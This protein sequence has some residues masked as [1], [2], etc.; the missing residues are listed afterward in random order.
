MGKLIPIVGILVIIGG[1]VYLA[2]SNESFDE[3]F[4]EDFTEAKR[5]VNEFGNSGEEIV[6]YIDPQ[7]PVTEFTYVETEV[8]T[9]ERFFNNATGQ[10]ETAKP[11][12]GHRV[13]QRPY[14]PGTTATR[15]NLARTRRR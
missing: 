15:G 9:Q 3:T 2:D 7:P 8:T 6:F 13:E 1:M 4:V 14:R 5:L 10:V 11:E 12:L